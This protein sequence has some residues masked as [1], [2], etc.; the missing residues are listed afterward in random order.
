MKTF[1]YALVDCEIN[2]DYPH[3]DLGEPRHALTTLPAGVRERVRA[4]N[5]VETAGDRV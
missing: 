2:P 3:W 5:A 4:R 1:L